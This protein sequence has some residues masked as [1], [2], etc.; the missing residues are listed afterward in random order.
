[1]SGPDDA[2]KICYK[3]KKAGHLS[4]DCQELPDSHGNGGLEDNPRTSLGNSANEM[5]RVAMEED[6]IH[7]IGEE[8]REIN[9][10]GL[11]DWES[12]GK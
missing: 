10:C 7:E 1:M 5:D 12:A 4:R 9:R 2:P 8:E 11:L 6:D 3:C